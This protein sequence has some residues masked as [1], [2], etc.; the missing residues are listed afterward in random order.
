MGRTYDIVVLGSTGYSGRKVCAHL[1]SHA[2]EFRW[3]IGGRDKAKLDA[4]HSELK[5]SSQVGIVVVDNKDRDALNSVCSNT[6]V[7]LACAG[8]FDKV[9]LPVVEACVKNGTHYTDIT[10]EFQF[11]RK[12]IEAYHSVAEEKRVMLVPCCG[13]DCVPSDLGNWLVHEAARAQNA[14]LESVRAYFTASGA[15]SG[16]TMASVAN[17]FATIERKDRSPASLNP[18][19]LARVVTPLV[20]FISYCNE[21]K[22]WQGPYIMAAINERI[23]RRSNAL[24]G[25]NAS[26]VEASVGS[27]AHVAVS[28]I[29][30]AILGIS[31]S[32]APLRN[33]LVKYVFPSQGTGP[34]DAQLAS[35]FVKGQFVGTTTNG[36]SISV[37]VKDSRDAYT[38]TGVFAAQCAMAAADLARRDAIPRG[39]VLTASVAFGAQLLDR[40]RNVGVTAEVVVDKKQQ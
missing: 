12:M 23:V 10:G 18:P 39:G 34:S 25:N 2:G 40:V 3:A 30:L 33:L 1:A 31:L 15:P 36:Q 5:L 13:F 38:I 29:A 8:P 9:G 16:G 21:I 19:G 35:G 24:S 7:V 20:K 6:L 32:I 4:L 22:K 28:T 11:V 26:Y 27:F 14:K 17:L 37:N